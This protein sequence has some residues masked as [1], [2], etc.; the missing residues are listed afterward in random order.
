[1]T[2]GTISG[3]R[4]DRRPTFTA[5][6][7]VG[8]IALVIALAGVIFDARQAAATFL[9][10]YVAV[11]S[12]ALGVLAMVMIAHLTT[13]TW[14]G[15]FR[16]RAA[17]V[18]AALPALA[19]LG[20]LV[21]LALPVLFPWTR[22][23]ATAQ[24][25]LNIPFFIARYV[26]Y[27]VAW[28]GIAE[29]LRRTAA[30]EARGEV[31]RAARRYRRISSAGLV[32]L[33]ITMTFAAFDWMMSLTPDWSSTIYGVYWFAGGM[34]GG[35]AL[36]ALLSRLDDRVP[37]PPSTSQSLGKLLLTFVLFWLYIAFA[38]YIVIWS[39]DLP[40]EVTWYVPRTRGAWAGLALVLLLGMFVLPFL[41]LIVRAVKRSGAALAALGALLL[42]LHWADTYW[43]VMPDL[44]GVSWWTVIVAVAMAVIVVEATVVFAAFRTR[45][46]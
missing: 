18:L 42:V 17:T 40:R 2:A 8:I 43:M 7:T 25:Y 31:M 36:L 6:A 32:V 21:L 15:A 28:I 45:S 26:V 23:P 5:A 19:V 35:L 1:M 3:E 29:L 14:F 34:V 24:K 33:A 16:G 4:L 9:V 46:R 41:A 20:L 44:V 39:G 22:A 38:Q 13:A 27:W 37:V 10:S 12:V 11:V 30:V